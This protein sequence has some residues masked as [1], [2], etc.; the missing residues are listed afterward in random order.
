MATVKVKIHDRGNR[1][2]ENI[3]SLLKLFQSELFTLDM[4]LFYLDKKN[5]PGIHDY[6]VNRLYTYP[7][8][9]ISFYI[10]EFCYMLIKRESISLERFLLDKCTKTL[11]IFLKVRTI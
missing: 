6:L 2:K 3:G 8:H 5:E 10:A 7:D 11:D 9:Q 1:Q 4:C